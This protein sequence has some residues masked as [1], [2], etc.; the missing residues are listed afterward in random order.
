MKLVQ[1]SIDAAEALALAAR[2]EFVDV[3]NRVVRELMIVVRYLRDRLL[4]DHYPD[5]ETWR[6]LTRRVRW[7]VDCMRPD[8][9]KPKPSHQTRGLANRP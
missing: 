2:Y 3:D 6:E 4:E 1:N 9:P 7:A 8:E 5:A